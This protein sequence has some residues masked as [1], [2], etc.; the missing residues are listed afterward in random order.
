AE[1]LRGAVDE[2]HRSGLPVTAHAH[3][4]PAIV[5]ALA[6][7]VDG[8]EHLTFWSAEGVDCSEALLRAVA[9]QRVVV[10]ATVGF[11]PVADLAPPEAVASRRPRSVAN[12]W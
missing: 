10:G 2:S 1:L 6:A 3:G 7:G 11:V 12:H 8:I 5:D 9:D 4:T